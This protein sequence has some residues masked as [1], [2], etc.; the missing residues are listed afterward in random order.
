MD[1]P[2]HCPGDPLSLPAMVNTYQCALNGFEIEK[3]G[4]NA[5]TEYFFFFF[6]NKALKMIK[7]LKLLKDKTLSWGKYFNRSFFKA[8]SKF[9]LDGNHFYGFW[10]GFFSQYPS[11]IYV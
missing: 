2:L 11:A 5:P 3:K 7:R 1:Q 4:V 6:L 9:G 8:S 10:L